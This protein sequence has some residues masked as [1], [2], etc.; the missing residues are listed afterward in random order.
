VPSVLETLTSD[1]EPGG[2]DGVVALIDV[3]LLTTTLSAGK[4]PIVTVA[5]AAKSV[6]DR[7]TD[8]PPG[9]GPEAG[10]IENTI[11]C[12]ISDVL[13]AGSYGPLRRRLKVFVRKTAICPRVTG[14]EGQ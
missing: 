1:R 7:V 3:E 4:P 5:P 8:E 6:P 9:E 11:R 10:A 14:S 2:R 12:E 13:P